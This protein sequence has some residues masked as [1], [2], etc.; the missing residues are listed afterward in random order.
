MSSEQ[1]KACELEDLLSFNLSVLTNTLTR[2]V[3]S[4]YS[5]ELE[6]GVTE[7]RI[8]S[9][10]GRKSPVSIRDIAEATRIDKGWISRSVTSLLKKE[11]IFKR[12]SA[13][14]ARKVELLLSKKGEAAFEQ[15]QISAI[16][17][18][19]KIMAALS[20]GEKAL[21]SELLVK[22]QHRADELLDEELSI[23]EDKY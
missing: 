4:Y 5:R 11:L 10:I 8:I 20:P 13:N 15:I 7:A 18:N 17:R 21:F 22:L 12:D 1:H 2:T 16:E 6:L 14:D 19:D 23:A 3:S 9:V